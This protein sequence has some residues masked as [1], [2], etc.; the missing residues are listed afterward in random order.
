[1]SENPRRA[2]RKMS[3]REQ[4][5]HA[6]VAL[7]TP[8]QVRAAFAHEVA[9]IARNRRPLL[10]AVF[11]LRVLMFFNPVS[12]VKF[13]Q[14]V[15]DEEKICDDIAV[16]LTG[17]PKALAGALEKFLHQ[18]A[19]VPDLQHQKLHAFTSSLEER[20]NN[21]HLESRIKRLRQG[22]PEPGGRVWPLG[23]ALAVTAVLN[24]FI[25]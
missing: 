10:M 19:E 18:G 1:M 11:V 8:E 9:H 22:P 20:N 3:V 15:R 21:L 23:A 6:D 12:L 2:I 13:R 16:N 5:D 7:L 4:R 14:A 24:Y 25:V 17:D